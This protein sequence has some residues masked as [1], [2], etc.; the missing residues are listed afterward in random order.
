MF[1]HLILNTVT[2]EKTSMPRA[3]LKPKSA[4]V[5][6]VLCSTKGGFVS[7]SSESFSLRSFSFKLNTYTS[8][9]EVGLR[10]RKVPIFW[11]ASWKANN[12]TPQC[13]LLFIPTPYKCLSITAGHSNKALNSLLSELMNMFTAAAST[14]SIWR[15]FHIKTDFQY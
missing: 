10:I 1:V 7:P 15:M 13:F 2:A 8:A 3:L 5:A 11:F 6:F 14:P 12:V 9:E 4:C